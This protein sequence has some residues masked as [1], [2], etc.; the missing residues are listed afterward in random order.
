[1]WCRAIRTNAGGSWTSAFEPSGRSRTAPS[2][3]FDRVLRQRNRLLKDWEGGGRLRDS[4]RGTRSSLPRR[5]VVLAPG[6][7]SRN[8]SGLSRG[9]SF[10]RCPVTPSWWS[11]S[12]RRGEPLEAAI[13]ARLRERGRMSWSAGPPSGGRTV[14]TFGSWSRPVAGLRLARRDLGGCSVPSPGSGRS[15]D[16]GAGRAP[17]AVSRRSV[18]RRWTPSGWSRT[19]ATLGTRGQ[20]VLAVRTRPRSP[21]GATVW[22]VKEGRVVAE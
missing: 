16:R 17:G 1:M 14:T 18:L 6:R 21:A 15:G 19:A 9:R 4:T 2:P 7:G 20:V 13:M 10:E 22:R 5:G 3:A 8:G 12:P 11:T